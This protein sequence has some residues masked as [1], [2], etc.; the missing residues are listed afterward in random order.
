MHDEIPNLTQK[1]L[2]DVSRAR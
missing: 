1:L 2:L